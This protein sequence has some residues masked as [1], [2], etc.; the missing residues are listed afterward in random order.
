MPYLNLK[1]RGDVPESVARNAARALTA[2]TAE[3]LGKKRE[4]TSVL[5][6]SVPRTQWFIAGDA[7][8]AGGFVTFYLEVK[9]TGGTNTKD[10]KAR[11]LREAFE[12]LAALVGKAHPVSYVVLHELPA[13]AWGYAG[14]TQE[15]R[16]LK[17]R[18]L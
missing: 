1:I 18:A 15:S 6:E 3:R 14:E 7:V 8:D 2:I 11:Y 10:E 5:I 13:D 17:G 9:I 4:L 12:A 16:Y